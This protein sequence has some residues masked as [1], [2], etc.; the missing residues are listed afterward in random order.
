[1]KQYAVAKKLAEMGAVCGSR[2]SLRGRYCLRPPGH[3]GDHSD[4]F[5][6]RRPTAEERL[7]RRL[8]K[9]SVLAETRDRSEQHLRNLLRAHKAKIAWMESYPLFR[10]EY[11]IRGG[12]RRLRRYYRFTKHRT[13]GRRAW[14][15]RTS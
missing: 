7:Q 3:A 8:A 6:K 15:A 10:L 2:R 5:E 1:V 11:R 13:W 4:R 9:K 12:L 14:K